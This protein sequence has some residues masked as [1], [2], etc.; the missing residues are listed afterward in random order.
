[1]LDQWRFY[2]IIVFTAPR[3]SSLVQDARFSSWKSWVQIPYAVQSY[4]FCGLLKFVFFRELR[5]LSDDGANPI[6]GT[7]NQVSDRPLFPLFFSSSITF[8]TSWTLSLRAIKIASSVSMTIMFSNPITATNFLS[9][10]IKQF[11]L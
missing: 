6:R 4:G 11:L 1:M 10:L 9:D 5:T 8:F 3:S 2:I 7:I